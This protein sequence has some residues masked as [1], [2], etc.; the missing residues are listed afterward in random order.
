MTSFISPAY[1]LVNNSYL[2][3]TCSQCL[4]LW[5]RLSSRRHCSSLCCSVPNT[6]YSAGNIHTY[7]RRRVKSKDLAS[8]MRAGH[9][10]REVLVIHCYH[11]LLTQRLLYSCPII[12]QVSSWSH[13]G[14]EKRKQ[15]RKTHF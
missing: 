1:L 12:I 13:T 3:W 4:L 8:T 9:A 10:H 6:F 14:Y 15:E 11:V 2:L 7:L 5:L